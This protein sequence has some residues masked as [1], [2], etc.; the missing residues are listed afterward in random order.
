[1][2][3]TGG[4]GF[5]VL[6]GYVIE[7]NGIFRRIRARCSGSR[8]VIHSRFYFQ[9]ICHT[10]CAGCGFVQGDDQGGK[11]DQFHDHLSHIVIKGN[12]L[13][14]LH[15]A[16]IYFYSCFLDQDD[17]SNIDQYVSDRI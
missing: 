12:N 14:L 7:Y 17:C 10:P 16:K 4:T 2:G 5:A 13:S 11:L 1:M 8:G 9:D 6:K 3:K 15:T